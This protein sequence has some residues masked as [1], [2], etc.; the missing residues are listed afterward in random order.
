MRVLQLID[1]LNTGGAERMAV[2]FANMLSTQI[3]GS[4]LCAT[5]AEGLLK[6]S[7]LKEVSYLFLNKK[8]TLDFKAIKKLS[9]YI[10]E[11]K[12][13]VIH[14]HATS[15]FLATLMKLLNPKLIVIWH[16]HYG[17]SEFLEQRP[18]FVLKKCSKFFNHVFTVNKTLEAW[19]RQNLLVKKVTFLSNFVSP[20][21]N[22]AITKLQG[23]S[24]KRMVCLANLRPQKDHLNLLKA[25]EIVVENHQDW[26][27]HLV[28]KDFEDDYAKGVKNHIF[29]HQLDQKVFIYGS[30]KDVSQ[31]LQSCDLGVL[32]SK[33]EG[34]PLALLE[35]G[36]AGLP[37][38]ATNVGDCNK[39]IASTDDGILVAPE[40]HEALAFAMLN[41][42]ENESL[43]Q[44]LAEN[45][46]H[47]VQNDFSAKKAIKSVIEVYKSY[48]K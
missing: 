1:T 23:M 13:D 5:R 2:N 42:I 12:I 3:K 26:T 18:R 16:D 38:V 10:I 21:T 8:S 4:Y 14:A 6:A 24:E 25:F 19:D 17:N 22:L 29:E 35:Y 32:S 45:L 31:I 9:R 27:L 28:G 44:Q 15:F 36:M 7:V 37:V 48:K 20:D 47:K 43:R 33:S 41:L 30:C 34:L 40:N 46:K 39:V 11:N